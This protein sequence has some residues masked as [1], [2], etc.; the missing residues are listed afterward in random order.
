MKLLR[1]KCIR[2]DGAND[3][4]GFVSLG[5][6][7]FVK[8]ETNEEENYYYEFVHFEADSD[9]I[10]GKNNG[11]WCG[12]MTAKVGGMVHEDDVY[13]YFGIDEPVPEIGGEYIDADGLVWERVE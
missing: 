13:Y 3:V 8:L 9:Y 4:S 12:Y 10:D 7:Y 6:E 11:F 2:D 1:M 5:T